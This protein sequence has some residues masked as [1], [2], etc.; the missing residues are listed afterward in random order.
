MDTDAINRIPLNGLS[1]LMY[2]LLI[3]YPGFEQ[4]AVDRCHT[5]GLVR[6]VQEH[7]WAST[8]GGRGRLN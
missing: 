4:G 7:Q 2:A 3:E 5:M 8:Q 1:H 6:C